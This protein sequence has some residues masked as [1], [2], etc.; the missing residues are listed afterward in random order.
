MSPCPP[1]RLPR[2]CGDLA[3][4]CIIPET[5]VSWGQNKGSQSPLTPHQSPISVP[6]KAE[7]PVT[8]PLRALGGLM[9]LPAMGPQILHPGDVPPLGPQVTESL[10]CPC[11]HHRVQLHICSSFQA[12]QS[13]PHACPLPQGPMLRQEGLWANPGPLLPRNGTASNSRDPDSQQ[14][15]LPSL[16]L[17]QVR[18]DQGKTPKALGNISSASPP[19]LTGGRDRSSTTA[20]QP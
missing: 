16:S 1:P 12:S 10:C 7:L 6:R 9:S 3:K 4:G 13:R 14:P 17:P 11:S 15:G 19:A 2:L 18:G 8:L 5:K 20:E